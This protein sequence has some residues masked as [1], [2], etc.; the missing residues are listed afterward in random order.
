MKK[1]LAIVITIG[2][3]LTV[4]A[5]YFFQAQLGPVLTLIID[6]GI[7]LVGVAGLVGIGYLLRL[8]FI[9]LLRH[10]KGAFFSGVVLFAFFFTLIAG[11]VLTPQ[12]AFFQDLVLN[13][14][15]P[16]EAS[17]LA[18]LA[19]T[20]MVISLRLIRTRGWTPMSTAFLLSTIVSLIFNL[21]LIRTESG[22]LAAN[23]VAFLHRLPLAGGR[24]ILLGVALG[25][26]IFG[27]RVLL[28]ID[29]PYGEE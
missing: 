20:L 28:T 21:G 5:G 10:E 6:W 16:V 9:K 29:R 18:I 26:L 3:G 24:G 1:I 23:L 22:T 14:Q 25:G 12:N 7:L 19:V 8:H 11:F 27:L 13:V 2:I 4:L 15:I 17:L